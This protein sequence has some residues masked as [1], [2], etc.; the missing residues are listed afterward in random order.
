[1]FFVHVRII[2]KLTPNMRPA[3]NVI[4]G[5]RYCVVTIIAIALKHT[6]KPRIK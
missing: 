3:T 4:N 6:S 2:I 5:V 1:M